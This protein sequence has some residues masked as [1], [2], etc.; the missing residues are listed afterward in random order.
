MYQCPFPSKLSF[1]AGGS[2]NE[3]KVYNL[4]VTAGTGAT[5]GDFNLL[6][7]LLYE[8]ITQEHADLFQ[9]DYPKKPAPGSDFISHFVQNHV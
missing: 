1:H 8:F 5:D 2:K 9:T 7:K 3:G 6:P 4:V